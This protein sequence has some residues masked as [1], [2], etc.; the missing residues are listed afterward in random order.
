VVFF[1][2]IP[3]LAVGLTLLAV[4]DRVGLWLHHRSGLP[5]YRDGHRPVHAAGLDELQS[6]FAPGT[7]HAVERR[8]AELVLREEEH[9]GAP[10]LVRVDLAR[11]QVLITR[12]SPSP[13]ADPAAPGPC[14]PHPAQAGA[15]GAVRPQDARP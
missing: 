3:G 4:L 9:D 10:P 7:R 6:V 12:P 1:L 11:G 2:T 5:W 13:Q 14:R 8:R 15:A